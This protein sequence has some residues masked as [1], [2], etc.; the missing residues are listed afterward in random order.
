MERFDSSPCGTRTP[1]LSR[2]G[3]SQE[4]TEKES[5]LFFHVWYSVFFLC[6]QAPGVRSVLTDPRP[7]NI[8]GREGDGCAAVWFFCFLGFFVF[9]QPDTPRPRGCLRSPGFHLRAG[10]GRRP[11]SGLNFACFISFSTANPP[12]DSH[13]HVGGI[14]EAFFFFCI[15]EPL[16]KTLTHN[17]LLS[18]DPWRRLHVSS[19]SRYSSLR[20]RALIPR[21]R[22]VSTEL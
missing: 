8:R 10:I 21:T 17:T 9:F 4:R 15:H 1:L 20:P 7:E 13:S 6:T 14:Q 22:R 3:S 5:N 19:E 18:V 2:R 16:L 11:G 12:P